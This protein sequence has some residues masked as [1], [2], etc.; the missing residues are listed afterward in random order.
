LTHTDFVG[1]KDYNV[2]LSWYREEAVRRFLVEKGAELNRFSSIG[3]GED[4]A[5]GKDAAGKAKDRHVSVR[6][7]SPAD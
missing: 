3:L 2:D 1:D 6:V 7:Y 5:P 4:V